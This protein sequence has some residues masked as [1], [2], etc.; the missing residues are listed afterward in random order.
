MRRPQTG[1]A[2]PGLAENGLLKGRGAVIGLMSPLQGLVSGFTVWATR[3]PVCLG[4]SALLGS[5]PP[6]GIPIS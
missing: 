2:W 3:G 1:L 5:V 4:I 6:V